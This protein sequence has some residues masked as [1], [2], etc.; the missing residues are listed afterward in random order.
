MELWVAGFNAW[1]Q[2]TTQL[3]EG[4]QNSTCSLHD[5]IYTFQNCIQNADKIHILWSGISST[6]T[7]IPCLV[8]DLCHLP[9]GPIKKISSGGYVSAALTEGND[10]YIWGGKLGQPDILSGLTN[11]PT[12]VDIEGSDIIDIAVGFDHIIA[13]TTEGKLYTVGFGDCGQL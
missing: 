6:L 12:P 1:G 13:L 5:D 8:E 9:T 7:P 11:N 2:L 4:N 10:L 3:N